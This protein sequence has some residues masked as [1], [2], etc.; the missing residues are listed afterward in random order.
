[1]MKTMAAIALGLTMAAGCTPQ[2]GQEQPA[3]AP[4]EASAYV[5]APACGPT[6]VRSLRE[7]L[8]DDRLFGAFEVDVQAMQRSPLFL[9]NKGMLEAEAKE[10]LDAMKAC[11]VPLSGVQSIAGGFGDGEKVVLGVQAKGIATPKT[12]DCLG[13]EI[14]KATGKA[15]WAR[16]TKVCSTTLDIDGGDS[17][18]FAVGT[19]MLV[20]ASKSMAEKVQRRIKGKDKALLGGQLGWVRHEVDMGS[21]MWMAGNLPPGAGSALGSSMS[22]M[23]RVGVS[24]DATRGLGMKVSAGFASAADAKAARTEVDGLAAQAGLMLPMLGLP[25]SVADTI[26]VDSKGASM[27]VAMFLSRSDIKALRKF[28]EDG[29]GTAAPEKKSPRR[30]I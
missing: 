11:G 12:L 26:V 16:T 5:A 23:S 27:T 7:L 22:G 30:G 13:R 24:V 3:P 9:D 21:T 17:V 15:P 18:G 29:S 10:A 19:D 8:P 25:S 20:V 6:S 2:T 14:E 1:M 4:L 28:A